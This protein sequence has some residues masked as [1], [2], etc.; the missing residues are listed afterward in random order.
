MDDD[1]DTK[2]QLSVD[3]PVN[4]Q[5][6]LSAIASEEQQQAATSDD[7]DKDDAASTSAAAAAN[8]SRPPKRTLTDIQGEGDEANGNS[9]GDDD[10]DEEERAGRD[11]AGNDD[12]DEEDEDD[13][14]EED[15]DD[16]GDRDR[17]R[18][19]K[20]RRRGGNQ[21]LDIEADVDEDEDEEEE[22]Q[23]EGFVAGTD[24]F[25]VR[26]REPRRDGAAPVG[27]D[28]MGDD[29]EEGEEGDASHRRL[30]RRRNQMRDREAAELA[31]SYRERY[32][33]MTYDA[34]GAEDWAPKAL[35][36]PSVN[37]PSIWRV[38]CK[39]GRERDLV[40]SLS[41]KAVALRMADNAPPMRIISAFHRDSIKGSL[42]I[43]AWGEDDVRQA[44][45]GLVGSYH[46]GKDGVYLVDIEETPDLLRTKQKK[47]EIV[48]GS[49]AR[50]KRG[51][52]AGDLAQIIDV[53]DNGEDIT[54]KFIPRIDMTPKEDV[55]GPDGKKRKKAV[56]AP[57]AFR[58]PQRFFN[59]EEIARVYGSKEVSRRPGD[60]YI[61]RNDSFQNGYIEKEFK[62]QAIQVEDVQP[63]IDEITRFVGDGTKSEN[64]DVFDLSSVA[65]AARKAARSIL[66]PGD[67]VEI[68]EGDQKGIYGTIDSI[69]NEIAQ[70]TPDAS[71]DLGDQKIEVQAKS[72][73]KRFSQGDHIKVLTGSNAGETGLVVRV[74]NDIVTFLSDVTQEQVEVFAKDVREAAEVGSGLNIVGKYELH[75]LVQLDAQTTG[76]IFKVDRDLLHVL[77]Q[78]DTVRILKASQIL[79]KVNSRNAVAVDQDGSEIKQ[80][81]EMKESAGALRQG[82]TGRVLHV[83]RSN[84][85]FLHNRE[86]AEN[87]GV[88]VAYARNLVSTAPKGKARPNTMMNPDRVGAAPAAPVMPAGPGRRDGRID[89][90]VAIIQGVNKGLTGII[91]DVV[92]DQAR[93]ELHSRTKVL[94]ISLSKLKEQKPDGK[95]VPLLERP[96]FGSYGNGSTSGGYVTSSNTAPLGS[97]GVS[98]G[99]TPF[100]SFGG[101]TPAPG[102]AG[103]RTPAPGFAGGRTPA[104]GFA[105]GRTPAPFAAGRTPVV[106]AGGRT[107]AQGFGG[108]TPYGNSGSGA[109]AIGGRTPGYQPNSNSG[110]GAGPWAAGSATPAAARS[111]NDAWNLSSA[112]PYV[113]N[114]GVQDNAAASSRTPYQP[115]LD[116]GKTP[117][118][119]LGGRTPAYGGRTTYRRDDEAPAATPATAPTP[120]AN[121]GQDDFDFP[122]TPAA[123][124]PTPAASKH[125]DYG[126]HDPKTPFDAPTPYAG[127]PTPYVGA[128][129]PAAPTPAANAYLGAPT[130]AAYGAAP[131]PGAY[132]GGPTPGYGAY[133]TPGTYIGAATAA[134][135]P[136]EYTERSSA[137]QSLP[138]DWVTDGVRVIF[139]KSSF[140]GG[141]VDDQYAV[142]K[143][144]N[145]GLSTVQLDS[146][147][148]VIDNVP[149]ASLLPMGPSRPGEACKVLT[150]P[151]RGETVQTQARDGAE[152]M[153]QRSS[154]AGVVVEARHLTLLSGSA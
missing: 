54:L 128:P 9:A 151:H 115:A 60:V 120:A 112:T 20:R 7:D 153:V 58:P 73:R 27:D 30:D 123:T 65:E 127:A 92:G 49:W 22:E 131:T 94:T 100:P 154:G 61:F 19:R 125:N 117:D 79:D 142:V 141:R 13:E 53:D 105:G 32:G 149:T 140:Q 43:E 18:K 113:A 145:S 89:R 129:T 33:K 99:R 133:Q 31:A 132:L 97:G 47:I 118:P 80:G 116:G 39:I 87:G 8:P 16:A 148:E 52:Y 101:R 69:V 98:S 134:A 17:P 122:E 76:V 6:L 67:Q 14:D 143:S 78:T 85:A 12:E 138:D 81:D 88:F 75:D 96:G 144:T 57:L 63:T 102:F 124:A 5:G 41:R 68:F 95:L 108:A 29:G 139:A 34:E 150:G 152:W 2:S 37:D 1:D 119:R 46:N 121:L 59:H 130:P 146:N 64:G 109:W 77:D 4:G 55:S 44:L 23:E 25:I 147:K 90:R 48:P 40:L 45:E 62:V 103:G 42:Y 136:L 24:D 71:F 107:P 83:Y 66:Q 51:K 111:G 74:Q 11:G 91:K 126:A 56:S 28:D 137:S 84:F 35:L 135:Q 36:M 15:E 72:M 110:A 21:F 3:E 50:I 93:V 106:A 10:E 82:R 38:K 114:R 26:G 70:I 86:V 104:P